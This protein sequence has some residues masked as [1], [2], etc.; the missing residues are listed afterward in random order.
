MSTV[1]ERPTLLP[2]ALARRHLA[3]DVRLVVIYDTDRLV[4]HR[5]SERTWAVL[6]AMDG[7]RDVAGLVAHAALLGVTVSEAE[8]QELVAD[9]ADN[10]L[11]G[12]RR[13][14]RKEAAEA[15]PA[16]SADLPIRQLPGFSFECDGKGGCCRFYP[17]I[18]FS[19]LD[20]ARARSHRP[21]VLDGGADETRVFLPMTGHARNMLAVTLVNGRCAYLQDDLACGIH[22]VS[23]ADQKPLGCRTY[24]ARFIDDGEAVRVAPWLECGCII[25]SGTSLSHQ[26]APLLGGTLTRRSTLDPAFFIESLPLEVLVG[27]SRRASRS[28]VVRWA[29][30][31]AEAPLEADGVAVFLALSRALELNGL[32]VSASRDALAAPPVATEGDFQAALLAF[33]PHVERFAGETW[34]APSDLVRVTATALSSAL[35]LLGSLADELLAGPGNHV[36]AERFYVRAVLFGHQLVQPKAL[37]PMSLLAFDRA[38]RLLLARSLAV[39]A[40]LADLEDPAFRWPIAVIDATLRG[41]GLSIY[42]RDLAVDASD[43]VEQSQSLLK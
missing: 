43:T 34:R 39:V 5:V 20:A 1:L 36:E 3:G 9:L 15:K 16:A 26:G 40:S 27:S 37:R 6:S 4:H 25:K 18:A 41:Y 32:D 29:D 22:A 33:T 11:V 14:E 30:A 21:A 42:I 7:T 24:P 23:E 19:P 35:S 13:T 38:F 2:H 10:G 17:T 12:E 31:L 28:E 8:V